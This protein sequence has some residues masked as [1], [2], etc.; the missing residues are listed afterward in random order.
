MPVWPGGK[1]SPIDTAFSV[2][3]PAG[4]Q[5]YVGEVSSQSGFY[6]GGTQQVVVVNPSGSFTEF[7]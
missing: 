3:I 2:N 4:T 7:R 1:L 6:V 5:V